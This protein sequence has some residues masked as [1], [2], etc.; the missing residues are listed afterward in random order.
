[1][2]LDELIEPGAQLRSL[3]DGYQFT[4]GPVWIDDRGCLE[5]VD[6]PGDV[7]EPER[8]LKLGQRPE[9][10]AQGV[11]PGG[12]TERHLAASAVRGHVRTP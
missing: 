4:E 2:R 8:V 7:G 1:M 3:G 12:E 11:A 5:F 10:E 9:G 6:I